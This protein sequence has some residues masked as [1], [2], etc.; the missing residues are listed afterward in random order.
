MK[1]TKFFKSVSDEEISIEASFDLL[2]YPIRSKIVFEIVLK[3]EA[4]AESL[5]EST[6]KSRSTISHHLKKL[7]ESGILDVHMSPTGKTKYY[8]IT[9]NIEKFMYSL[10][11]EKFAAGTKEEQST[12]LIEMGKMFIIANQIFSSIYVDQ[13]KLRQ[14]FKPF[15]EIFVKKDK[16]ISYRINKRIVEVPYFTFFFTGEEQA[17]YLRMRLKELMIDFSKEFK[18]MPDI[19]GMLSAPEKHI[20]NL[21]ILPFIDE[22]ELKDV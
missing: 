16:A 15:D 5:V 6:G 22:E 4:T 17:K 14:K 7:V 13:I 3:G 9:Q 20:V 10:D 12:F 21:Q 11:K 19:E 8:R 2:L 18:E 1:S